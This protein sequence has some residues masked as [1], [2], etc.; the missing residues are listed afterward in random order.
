[1]EKCSVSSCRNS[2]LKTVNVTYHRYT[3][4]LLPVVVFLNVVAEDL[5]GDMFLV[6]KRNYNFVF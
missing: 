3:K 5:Y 1:M 4:Q 2:S 6:A